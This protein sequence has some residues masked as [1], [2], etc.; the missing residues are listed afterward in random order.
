M[1]REHNHR[2]SSTGEGGSSSMTTVI[3][4]EAAGVDE[5][6][7]VLGYKVRSSDMADVAHKLEQ[8]EMVL[9]D[10]ISNLSDETVHYNPSDL[11]GWVESM[12]SDLDPTRTQEKPDSEYD[13]RAIPGSAVY[14]REEHVT[15]RNK[16]TR[17]ESELTS[18]RSVVVLDSQ[19]TGVRLVHALLAC[20]EAVQ[21]NNLKLADALV[22]HVGLLAS[23]QAGA[24]RKVATYFAEGLARRIYRIY[25]RDD[26]ALSSFSDILQIHF[27]ESCPY[28]K[29]AHFTANQAIL[30][31]FAMAE[32]VHVIDLGLNHGLQWP[33][34]IQALALRPNGP[35]DFRLTG[36]GSS[37]TDIQEV[38]WK[39]GQLAST[40]GV[41]FEFK[42]IALNNLSD[43]KPEM[44]NIRPGSESVAVNSV[45]E[46]HRLLAH[47][48]SI[49][50]FLS[51]IKSIRPNIMTVV[52]QEANHNGAN[53][54]DRFTE[55]LH[56][57]SSL[58]D[59]LEGP[60]SQDRVMSELFL[61]RQILNLVACEGEDRV[62]RH[63]TLNQW[64]NRF[65]SGG[66][67]PVNIGSNAYKQA[68]MLLALY[69]GADGYNVE[70]N[71]GCLLLG[72]QTRPLIAT[73]A[74]R[75]NRVE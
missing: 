61:G 53:F 54:L 1:K 71:E 38:G 5:L 4:E 57:Y 55:S 15:R 26:V 32:K 19:E 13:L 16:R 67:E 10:G 20:A 46:L 18:T 35:P 24:M 25:P 9:G 59:S 52:E 64:R 56:Y 45:F 3:K 60:P 50:K 14:P 75:I 49:D 27:Y 12:L 70:E 8:L 31:A 68:S 34:L 30:E 69:A 47:P 73:S 21:Q 28:L 42:S 58:F 62:E 40:I 72:W 63:E 44:L 23:S 22:K 33:A 39:L 37:L 11:S 29:F 7:V 36:I 74:W 6:L 43:L 17:I 48:G 51:T 2:E 65:G 41:N 66:F